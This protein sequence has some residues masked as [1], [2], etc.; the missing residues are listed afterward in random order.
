MPTP[1]TI[2]MSEENIKITQRAFK[3]MYDKGFQDGIIACCAALGG[4]MIIVCL[5][6]GL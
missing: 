4:I 1:H 2:E 3:K 6:W 5:I